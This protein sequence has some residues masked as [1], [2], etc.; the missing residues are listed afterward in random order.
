[1]GFSNL[2]IL[3]PV[4]VMSHLYR[5]DR[6]FREYV[7]N[8][9]KSDMVAE[10]KKEVLRSIVNVYGPVVEELFTKFFDVRE[11][12]EIP[13]YKEIV[14]LVKNKSFYWINEAITGRLKGKISDARYTVLTRDYLKNP[15]KSDLIGNGW[16]I[17]YGYLA[18]NDQETYKFYTT[19]KNGLGWVWGDILDE[20]VYKVFGSKVKEYVSVLEKTPLATTP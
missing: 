6:E 11:V 9:L 16:D 20:F 19:G 1:M 13:K 14:D 18:E 5:T 3:F 10:K 15:M 2:G 4:A 8:I 12:S 17:Y 7:D